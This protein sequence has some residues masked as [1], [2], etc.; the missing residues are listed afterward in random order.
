MT[1][2]DIK[3]LAEA[4]ALIN[5]IS[6]DRVRSALRNTP[7]SGHAYDNERRQSASRK[8]TSKD[9]MDSNLPVVWGSSKNSKPQ[10]FKVK[11]EKK[12][13]KGFHSF[14]WK[15]NSGLMISAYL[16]PADGEYNSSNTT[17]FGMTTDGRL[18]SDRFPNL[19]L[20]DRSDANKL[21]QQIRNYMSFASTSDDQLLTTNIENA[22]PFIDS[23]KP[24]QLNI[25]TPDDEEL[26]QQIRILKNN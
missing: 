21:L 14:M 26:L 13:F 5:E 16:I 25:N 15:S 23:L 2:N 6:S 4:Y 10:A 17:M 24:Q 20:V 9:L 12:G 18:Y 19:Y 7:S 11:L 22:K 8:A 3:F 1:N